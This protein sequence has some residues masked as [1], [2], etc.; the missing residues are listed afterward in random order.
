[1]WRPARHAGRAGRIQTRARPG[2]RGSPAPWAGL[3]LYACSDPWADTYPIPDP[4][5][6]HAI[7]LGRMARFQTIFIVV[8]LAWAG[9]VRADVPPPKF[10]PDASPP[11][12]TTWIAQ[13][14]PLAARPIV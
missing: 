5:S 4:L 7:R 12:V 10:A 1:G 2:R 13:R 11:D 3:Y 8:V 6:P 14:A 9:A